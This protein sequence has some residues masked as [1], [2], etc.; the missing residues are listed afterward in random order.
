MVKLVKAFIGS[1]LIPGLF[2]ITMVKI[3]GVS[4]DRVASLL[5]QEYQ[6]EEDARQEA[7]KAQCVE[8]KNYG[9]EEITPEA[10]SS[11]P[12]D[13][14][15]SASVGDNGD[16]ECSHTQPLVSIPCAKCSKRGKEQSACTH[17]SAY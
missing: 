13:E 3:T 11:L 15:E 1:H 2:L 14:A 4:S 17:R 7:V 9:A 8:S 12:S 10:D 6:F 16:N 5:L